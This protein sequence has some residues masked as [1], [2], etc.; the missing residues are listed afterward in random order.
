M[1]EKLEKALK[2]ANY[3]VTL[4]N[5]RK[6]ALEEFKQNTIYYYNGASFTASRELISFVKTLIELNHSSAPL[7][8]DNG[9]PVDVKDLNVFLEELVQSHISALNKYFSVYNDLKTKR[10]VE[11][12]VKL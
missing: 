6:I 4:T 12:L 3:M 2:V 7:L 11:D 5:Q 10:K 1:D 9:I 8:D